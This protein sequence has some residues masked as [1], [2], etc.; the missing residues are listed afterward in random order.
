MKVV[1]FGPTEISVF[2]LFC[3]HLWAHP[4]CKNK[5]S[6]VQ[7]KEKVHKFLHRGK[8]HLCTQTKAAFVKI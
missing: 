2:Q 8:P 5:V 6:K 4:R 3:I 1:L 7:N